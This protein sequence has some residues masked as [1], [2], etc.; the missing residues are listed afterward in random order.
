MYSLK[1]HEINLIHD[2][3]RM[4]TVVKVNFVNSKKNQIE[5]KARIMNQLYKQD[6]ITF[7]AHKFIP[8]SIF[9]INNIYIGCFLYSSKNEEIGPSALYTCP[10]WDLAL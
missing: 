5:K 8:N 7:S 1:V 9:R 10:H 6:S 2:Y 3:T 4:H